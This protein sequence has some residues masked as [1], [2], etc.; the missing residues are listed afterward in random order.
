MRAAPTVISLKDVISVTPNGGKDPTLTRMVRKPY[1]ITKQ[2]EKWT[3]QE[4]QK[5][6]EALKLYGRSWGHI[7]EHI[8]TKT[9][10]QIRSHAQKFFVKVERGVPNNGVNGEIQHI[11][12]PP[13]R[14]KRKPSHPY[15]RKAGS[16]PILLDKKGD[17]IVE[18]EAGNKRMHGT[19]ISPTPSEGSPGG[20]YPLDENDRGVLEDFIPSS[21]KST[22]PVPT[23]YSLPA[24]TPV[25]SGPLHSNGLSLEG[26]ALPESALSS[27]EVGNS[28]N[29]EALSAVSD[30]V[31]LQNDQKSKDLI[32]P[33]VSMYDGSGKK[34]Q[35]SSDLQTQVD[36]VLLGYDSRGHAE[37]Q[38]ACNHAAR[39]QKNDPLSLSS[40]NNMGTSI[41]VKATACDEHS[42]PQNSNP[43]S[44]LVDSYFN[45]F[46]CLSTLGG[47]QT[48]V[49]GPT[50]EHL[51][52][53]TSPWQLMQAPCVNHPAAFAAAMAAATWAMRGSGP[54]LTQSVSPE[55]FK[56]AVFAAASASW[57]ALNGL[58]QH[59]HNPL[60]GGAFRPSN[61]HTFADNTN[62]PKQRILEEPF[63]GAEEKSALPSLSPEKL[64][65]EKMSCNIPAQHP[66]PSA[67][68]LDIREHTTGE[69]SSSGSNTPALLSNSSEQDIPSLS[70]NDIDENIG[71]CVND[72][73]K[74]AFEA[75]SGE[76]CIKLKA[77][78]CERGRPQPKDFR[79]GDHDYGKRLKSCHHEAEVR[80]EVSS[81]GRK[82]FE[83]LF[84]CRTLP[85]TFSAEAERSNVTFL[86]G[87]TVHQ[88]VPDFLEGSSAFQAE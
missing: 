71:L 37:S 46:G 43:A 4:H 67:D 45:Y 68:D 35:E 23:G 39:K 24:N 36:T 30:K 1:T 9:T 11:E 52:Y 19:R 65:S 10:V 42:G 27:P 72:G 78:N 15:P 22:N 86:R 14:P 2:R 84:T 48:G 16:G 77:K 80:K 18:Q 61:M 70:E 63:S 31:A 33:Q 34:S 83:A 40:Q 21:T 8:G 60:T 79:H 41:D 51:P 76:G 57:W 53:P 7:K 12:I 81:Q 44:G 29:L 38:R 25:F 54:N 56:A 58:V 20:Y 73:R 47:L 87:K 26:N 64:F 85:Q 55:H 59:T 66:S 74:R 69:G 88:T 6:L 82:A 50:H 62:I 28:K 3:E 5:F 49:P 32:L 17:S 75:L 13:P